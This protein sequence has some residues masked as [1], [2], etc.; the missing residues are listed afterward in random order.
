MS[1]IIQVAGNRWEKPLF[2]IVLTT[3]HSYSGMNVCGEGRTRHKFVINNHNP[4]LL[5]L[6]RYIELEQINS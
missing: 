3:Y 2:I 4:T 6:S 1:I 5:E